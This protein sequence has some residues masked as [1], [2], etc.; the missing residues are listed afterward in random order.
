M[1]L[2]GIP[3]ASSKA[4]IF[5]VCATGFYSN[6]EDY[7]PP[8]QHCEWPQYRFP[9]PWSLIFI[10]FAGKSLLLV[11]HHIQTRLKQLYLQ[12]NQG[13]ELVRQS[14]DGETLG[15]IADDE[16]KSDEE[17]A[18]PEEVLHD[19]TDVLQEPA[20]M[21]DEEAEEEYGTGSWRSLLQD[22]RTYWIFLIAL[23]DVCG[24]GFAAMAL[25]AGLPLGLWGVLK[26]SKSVFVALFSRAVLGKRKTTTQWLGVGCIVLAIS[27][28]SLKKKDKDSGQEQ[29]T[30]VMIR[31]MLFVIFAEMGHAMQVVLEEYCVK[32]HN[33]TPVVIIGCLG[34][35]GMG[36]VLLVLLIGSTFAVTKDGVS[37]P[38]ND[39]QDALYMILGTA[40]LPLIIAGYIG[41]LAVGDVA[42]VYISKH[43]DSIYRVLIVSFKIPLLM[44]TELA[45]F[46]LFASP[47]GHP[48][49]N[50][51][52]IKG[53]G[54]PGDGDGL[55][56]LALPPGWVDGYLSHG[57]M[58]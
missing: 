10:M 13:F 22:C 8:A 15:L 46:Y 43:L 14:S 51:A 12:R 54:G 40:R 36:L 28:Y 34:P 6:V 45:L 56:S 3:S 16:G 35:F 7:P 2:A 9:Y 29:S 24:A 53:I 25:S 49:I 18:M 58:A 26:G 38:W 31:S 23:C 11:V 20:E 55:L 41:A 47:L 19:S 52:E 21:P 30:S 37:H 27:V 42:G 33:I 57:P 48:W 5:K 39:F 1:I 4:A 44:V 17:G 32:R 50:G